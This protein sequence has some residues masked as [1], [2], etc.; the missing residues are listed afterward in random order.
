MDNTAAN[1]FAM[2]GSDPGSR[3]QEQRHAYRQIAGSERGGDSLAELMSRGQLPP[4]QENMQMVIA[5]LK[6][7]NVSADEKAVL[8][9]MLGRMHWSAK[10]PE[11]RALVQKYLGELALSTNDPVLGKVAAQTYARLAYLPDALA[12]LD[13]AR[14]AGWISADDYYGDFAHLLPGAPASDQPA[15]LA[16]LG[17]GNNPFARMVLADVMSDRN[18]VQRMTPQTAGQVAGMLAKSEPTFT[19]Q[20]DAIGTSRVAEYENWLS[21]SVALTAKASGD[22]EPAV[23]ARLLKVDDDPRKLLAALS[24]ERTSAIV[25]AAFDRQS[26]DRIAANIDQFGKRHNNLNVRGYVELAQANLK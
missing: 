23:M 19:N 14:T 4:T 18:L 10:D 22:S 17:E 24:N 1:V 16:R 13:R 25:K 26:L 20:V 12:V 3:A 6:A 15:L 9:Q 8:A 11:A 5:Q 21:A 7:T 2:T